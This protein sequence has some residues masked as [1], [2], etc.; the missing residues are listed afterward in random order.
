MSQVGGN[1]VHRLCYSH[2]K[3]WPARVP[4]KGVLSIVGELAV[5]GCGNTSAPL[6]S[7]SDPFYRFHVFMWNHEHLALSSQLLKQPDCVLTWEQVSITHL[8]AFLPTLDFSSGTKDTLN[9]NTLT[10]LNVPSKYFFPGG[11]I[12][13]TKPLTLCILD[14]CINGDF[15]TCWFLLH[16]CIEKLNISTPDTVTGDVSDCLLMVIWNIDASEKELHRTENLHSSQTTQRAFAINKVSP[17]CCRFV[18]NHFQI[19]L[20]ELLNRPC[21]NNSD[22]YPIHMLQ[23]QSFM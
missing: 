14:T 20:F 21:Q 6:P 15:P 1:V 9:R 4:A 10:T 18:Q 13:S 12:T 7:C 2:S 16:Q 8:A 11:L 22:Y 5:G 19:F 17:G 3:G 23:H